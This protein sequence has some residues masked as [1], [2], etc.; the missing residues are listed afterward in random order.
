MEKRT[1]AIFGET[2]A[3]RRQVSLVAKQNPI[4]N[5]MQMPHSLEAE[6][7][8]LGAVVVDNQHFHAAQIEPEDF[9]L[10]QNRVI[11]RAMQTLI[12]AGGPVDSVTLTDCLAT[13]GKLDDAG[14]AAY[15]S[16]V[17]DGVPRVLNV[18]HYAQIVKEKSL[19]RLLI[20]GLRN[21]SESAI[22]GESP[23]E[24]IDNALR[25]LLSLQARQG[26]AALPK[27]WRE[28]IDGALEDVLSA[29]HSPQNVARFTF[30]I[31]SLDESTSG[32]R[33]E[34]IVLIVGQTGH[35]KSIAAM[36][37]ATSS[38]DAGYKGLVFSAEMSKEAL[39]KRELA[40]AAN[41]PM[42][43]LRRPEQIGQHLDH[44][45]ARERKRQDV[46]RKLELAAML[47][48]KRTLKIVDRDITPARVWSLS[49]MVHQQH[50]LDFVIVDY[51][52]LVIR[53]G[54]RRRGGRVDDQFAEQAQFMND[55]LAL[56]KELK[57]CFVLLCQPRKVSED[58]ARGSAAP[59]I[60]EIFGSSAVANT[61]HHVLWMMRL[62]FQ[63]GFRKEF[64]DMAKCFL[65]KARNDRATSIELRFDPERVRFEDAVARPQ[66]SKADDEQGE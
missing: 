41:I 61:A 20:H 54:M 6:K 15:I 47:E 12:G 9:Y 10:P 30:G 27:E 1:N 16:T 13:S 62:F 44:Q 58:V 26:A 33:R 35:G 37:L 29:I 56:A 42:W 34:D 66:E 40:H 28:A 5:D 19:A 49:R 36:Q 22:A 64:E 48:R 38:E 11:F 50:G 43:Y 23:Q 14:G 24:L 52:Q 21:I 46:I 32:F 60:E 51:D 55:A 8:L 39:A 7:T 63:K 25:L 59:R 31:P 65:L 53:E 45:D 17:G 18:A 57:I 4:Q 3:T 2:R